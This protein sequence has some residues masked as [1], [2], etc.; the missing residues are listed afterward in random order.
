MTTIHLILHAHID[1]IWLWPWTSGLDMVLG[2]WRTPC[3]L[4]DRHPDLVYPGDGGWAYESVERADPGLFHRIRRHVESGRWELIGGWWVQPDCNL[5]LGDSFRKQIEIGRQYF[6]S[7]FG[8]FPT[9]AF[10]PDSFG[11]SAALPA[12]LR[13]FG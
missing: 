3:D 2:T 13:E 9:L 5:P 4:L 12:I 8:R 10:N 6:M 1:P 7:R 11:H